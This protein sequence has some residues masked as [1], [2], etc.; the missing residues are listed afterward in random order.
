MQKTEKLELNLIET[1]DM[2]VSSLAAINENFNKIETAI[3][4]GGSDNNG[5]EIVTE[6]DPTVPQHVKEIQESDIENWND[7]YTKEEVDDMI[8]DIESILQRINSGEGV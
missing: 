2:V 1:T 8:G 7:K 4:E 5:G 6:T 3:E